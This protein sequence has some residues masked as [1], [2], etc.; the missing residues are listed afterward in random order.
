VKVLRDAQALFIG[1]RA[2][3]SNARGVRASELR[4]DAD[5][6]ADDHVTLLVDGLHDRRNGFVFRTN[7]NGAIWDGQV[8]GVDDVNENWNG[9]WTV[10]VTRDTAGWT[11]E[12]RIPI[13]T[14]R[15]RPGPDPTLGFNVQRF[16]RR[17]NEEDLWT[18]FGRAQG[19]F[20]LAEEGEIAGLKG[21][22]PIRDIE[23]RPYALARAIEPEHDA[24]GARLH[25]GQLDAKS[26]LDVKLGVSATVT[27]D[28]TVNTDFSQVE[29]DR[30][31]VNL[32][33]FPLFFPEKREF[34][35]ESSGV[36]DFGAASRAQLFYSRRVGLAPDGEPVPI[37][38]GAR[39]YGKVGPWSA[40]ALVA[41]TG[42]EE[43]AS[44]MVVRVRH[45]LLDRSYVG[46][47]LT[48]RSGPGV[49]GVERAAGVDVD[50]PLVVGGRNLE[51]FFWIA[52]TRTPE[53][54]GTR[55]AWRAAVD[56]PNDLFDNFVSLHRVDSGFEPTLGFVRRAGILETTGHVDF[57]PRPGVLGVRQLD[58][59][60]PSWDV[61]ADEHGSLG[62]S[63]DWQ[64][65]DFEVRPLG[66]VLQSGDTFELNLQR[67]LDAPG[68][69]FEVF[70]GVVIPSGRYWWSRTEIQVET[71]PGRSWSASSV[72]SRGGFYDG[73]STEVTVGGT[74]RSAGHLVV[75]ADLTRTWVNL[76]EG[77]FTA[78]Q[79]AGR[80]EYAFDTRRDLLAFLQYNNEDQR[81]DFQ[82]R[83]HWIPTVGDDVYVVWNSGYTTDPDA[84]FR[85]PRRGALGHPLN[86]ALAVKVVHRLAL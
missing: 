6:E 66:G 63:G 46:A 7:P 74:L 41:R 47:I 31:V 50:L 26:G 69:G 15:I 21:L 10:A 30:Q 37:L 17:K 13:S 72:L 61:I 56:Y 42:G 76:P 1:V 70:P 58:I 24:A 19:L 39:L 45:D 71:S 84:P 79:A 85:F 23:L 60:A 68:E 52:G 77:R 5:L 32:T 27:A 62:R 20:Q 28:L 33:R 86:G 35:L 48:V 2:W 49:E 53:A 4:R 51:P 18:S 54:A 12:F 57:M 25:E 73:R 36:F 34:F 65:A 55:L 43:R 59:E 81:I 83:F 22:V 82:F 29:A 78:L 3:D 67:A 44:D 75:A 16:I 11:A 80:L 9:I 38:G 14:L 64:T 8:A 40:G